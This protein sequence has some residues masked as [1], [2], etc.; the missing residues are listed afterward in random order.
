L[1][2]FNR[3]LI[4]KTVLE[5]NPTSFFSKEELK[6]LEEDIDIKIGS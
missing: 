5:K 3:V 2:Y 6:D 1:V 4:S